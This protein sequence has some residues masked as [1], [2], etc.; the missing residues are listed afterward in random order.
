MWPSLPLTVS[1]SPA[2]TQA[3]AQALEV[4]DRAAVVLKENPLL[5][6]PLTTRAARAAERRSMMPASSLSPKSHR[7][8]LVLG[9]PP[10]QASRPAFG[11]HVRPAERDDFA[12]PPAGQVGPAAGEGTAWPLN[13]ALG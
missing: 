13:V 6:S 1:Q 4:A 3:E 5:S 9:L 7:R 10:G 8:L 11:V 12:Q 2:A